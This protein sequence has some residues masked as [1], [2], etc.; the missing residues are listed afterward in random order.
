MKY[1]DGMSYDE[2]VG[3]GKSLLR[4]FERIDPSICDRLGQ[5]LQDNILSPFFE[6]FTSRTRYKRNMEGIQ[7]ILSVFIRERSVQTPLINFWG[8]DYFWEN[9]ENY[10]PI[11]EMPRDE[12]FIQFGDWS[13]ES[14]GDAWL[15]DSAWFRISTMYVGSGEKDADACRLSCYASFNTPWQ[16]LSY[17]RCVA[18]EREMLPMPTL[19]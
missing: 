18:G 3:I 19:G 16:W 9:Q 7:G 17:L 2:G 6:E 4:M 14:D 5:P 15:V 11:C 13:G 8:I 1:L 12:G 10:A